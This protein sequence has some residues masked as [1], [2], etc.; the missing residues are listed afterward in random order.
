[1]EG[2]RDEQR[3]GGEGKQEENQT[4]MVLQGEER[5]KGDLEEVG[6]QTQVI[7]S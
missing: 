5:E 7:F 3:R 2:Q 6:V 4:E 1:M